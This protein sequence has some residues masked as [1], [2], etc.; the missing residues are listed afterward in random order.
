M[1]TYSKLNTLVNRF[2]AALARFGV[3]RGDIVAVMSRNSPDYI[4]AYFAALKLG[5][6]I[7]GI[8]FTF[9]AR[10]IDYQVNHSEPKVLVV[11]DVFAERVAEAAVDLPSVST[12]IL[13][14]ISS[15]EGP[16]DWPR[17]STLVA[18]GIAAP[19]PEFDVHEN[20][21][22]LLQYTSGTEAFPKGVMIPH[23]NYL[24]STTPAWLADVG[25]SP[26][27]VWLFLMPFFAIAGI[28]SMT[29][30][31]LLG[32]T[33]ILV[34]AVDAPRALKMI[35][36]DGVTMMAQTPTF[37]LQMTQ[38]DGFAD[39]N[40][41]TLSR[42]ITYGGTVPQAMI[43]GWRAMKPDIQWGTYWGQSELTQLGS[44]GWFQTLDDVPDGD[45]TWIGRPVA[46][47]EIRV[48]DEEGEDAEVGELICRSPSAMVGYFKDAQKTTEVFRDGW[49]HTGDLVRIDA[50]G[51]LFFFDR[52]KDM[53]KTGGMNVSSQEVERILY[54]FPGLLQVAVVGVP[55]DY[56]SEA[57]TAFVVP[58]ADVTIDPDEVIQHC[59]SQM[60]GYKVPKT[61][62]IVDDLPKDTQGKILKRELRKMAG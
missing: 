8:N 46:Q 11:E 25:V 13:S 54:A 12:Y 29:T 23:R 4:I 56:W 53:I 21:I 1:Y 36:E 62:H 60:A 51:N 35:E 18:D 2:A 27:E 38:V 17:F 49:L 20:D 42:C 26:D 39:A 52:R 7:T 43:D 37:Y 16:E 61:V 57:V 32:A 5:A 19:E 3:E 33:L 55:D 59:K 44:V 22:A 24:I 15:A 30:L 50:E 58:N 31:I 48:V 28:G 40:V 47:L 41:T 9:T 45:P 10:E 6:A 34:H 14:D